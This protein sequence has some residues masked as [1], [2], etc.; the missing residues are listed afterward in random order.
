[1]SVTA[2][3]P[4]RYAIRNTQHARWQLDIVLVLVLMLLAFALRVYQLD[5]QDLR[6]DEAATWVYS[7][8]SF[9]E[10]L[11]IWKVDPQPPLYYSLMHEWF[12]LAGTT[13]FAI[14][15]VSVMGGLLLVA[16]LITLGRKLVDARTG[17]LVGFLVAV[18]PYDIYYAQ[19]A[20]PYPL[21]TWLG[22]LSTLILWQALRHRRWRDWIAYGVLIAVLA[23]TH[24]YFFIIVAF[25]TLFVVW[26]AW[27]RRCIPWQYG[28][29][30]AMAGMLYLPWL[31]YNW[32]LVRNYRGYVESA[33]LI[34][35]L[36]RPLLAF[37]GG[38]LLSPPI[39][40]ING[41]I[42]WPLAGL[43]V[44]G[45][46]HVSPLARAAASPAPTAARTGDYR[47]K[48]L[49][50][51]MLYLIVPLLVVF[52]VSRFRPI[53]NERYLALASPAFFL[54]IGAGLTWSL[55]RPRTWL[56]VGSA[57]AAI[58][59]LVTGGIA[60]ANYYTDPSFA[61]SPP[62]RDV[63]DHIRRKAHPGDV[64]V[65]TAPMPEILYY[66]ERAGR[67]PT[68]LIPY[69]QHDP[70]PRVVKALEDTLAAHPRVWLIQFPASSR[71]V[72]SNVEPWLDRHSVRLDQTFFRILHVGLYQSPTEFMKTM[73]PQRA[74]F[75]DGSNQQAGIMQLE[76]FQLGKGASPPF[77]IEPGEKV[78][79]TLMWR[80]LSRPATA[81]TVFTHVVGPDGRLWGQ[82]DNPPVWGTYPTAEW[83]AGEI[84][85]DQ[86]LIPLKGDTP[87]G[88]YRVLVGLYDLA[89]G[90]RLSVLD[91]GGQPIGNS[92]RLSQPITV[93]AGQ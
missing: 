12:P 26:D 80:A 1:M 87:P 60:L 82:W 49:Q 57:V 79:L 31:V 25:Q 37:A 70:L 56:S 11:D 86:Y 71:Q 59:F 91:D 90:A 89:S 16:S 19:D 28:V 40:W 53:F 75:T 67:L 63:L 74:S 88:A 30:G 55:R 5:H 58:V 78:P 44:V 92:V 68:A 43:G 32:D 51:V 10:L 8:R 4:T 46:W 85:F 72:A 77:V 84:V 52:F 41:A 7:I 9:A 69:E 50:L 61:K 3:Q 13:E 65:Y 17:I 14:R 81:Y 47:H 24:Y 66:N 33:S 83:A 6:G 35:S 15:Y 27:Q 29:V 54:L 64:L 34:A 21:A 62:W 45:L 73:I 23:Y 76:G 22:V 93:A 2:D 42:L 20:R 36:G 18:N 38:Q 39:N 48:A